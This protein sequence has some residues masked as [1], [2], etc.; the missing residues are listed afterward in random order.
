MSSLDGESQCGSIG[1]RST[2][3]KTGTDV[4]S[5][6]G[7][8]LFGGR[9]TCIGTRSTRLA[10]RSSAARRVQRLGPL[11]HLSANYTLTQGVAIYQQEGVGH[12]MTDALTPSQ[13]ARRLDLSKSRIIQLNNEGQLRAIRTSLGRLF[14]IEE[15]ERY[16]LERELTHASGRH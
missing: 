7:S 6:Y 16:A 4:V 8:P 3:R 13:T 10:Y 12:P 11:P 14:E 5:P 1:V 9:C 2:R 15:V